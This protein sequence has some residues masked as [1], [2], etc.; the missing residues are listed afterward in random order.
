MKF[1]TEKHFI[2]TERGTETEHDTP[3]CGMQRTFQVSNVEHGPYDTLSDALSMR[4]RIARRYT[5]KG[6]K[7]SKDSTKKTLHLTGGGDL[8]LT[9]SEKVI[10][11]KPLDTPGD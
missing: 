5:R 11:E 8:Y 10:S 2:L 4:Q 6:W 3:F 7:K 9:I 1:V